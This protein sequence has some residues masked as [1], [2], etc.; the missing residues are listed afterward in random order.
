MA[1][2]YL[3][4]TFGSA[5]NQK[6]WT[7]SGWIKRGTITTTQV[8][9]TNYTSSSTRQ[10]FRFN[11][12]DQFETYGVVGGT[13]IIQANT[14][15]V[16]RDVSA[17]YHVVVVFNTTESTG[18]NRCKVYINGVQQSLT[19][20]TTPGLDADGAINDNGLHSIGNNGNGGNY[21][22]GSMAMVQFVDG[23]AYDATYFGST[24]STTGIWTSQASSTISS[25]G[26]NGFK[27]AMDT[28]TPGADTSG[29]TN[30][31]T[32]SGT[33]TLT[34]GSPDNNWCTLNPLARRFSSSPNTFSNGNTTS[35]FPAVNNSW[36]PVS[37][38]FG[39]TKGKW[40]WES[41]SI[42]GT[43]TYNGI[44]A[45][46]PTSNTGDVWLGGIA[47][48][49]GYSGGNGY[50]YVA[51]SN[52]ASLS[53]YT[54][55]DIVS[56]AYDAD[57]NLI[58]FYKNGAIQNSGTGLAVPTPESTPLGAWFPAWSTWDQTTTV[59]SFNF[60]EGFFGT[61]AAGTQADDNGQGLFAYDVPAGYYALNTKNLEAYG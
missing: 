57:N 50:V 32:A 38:T 13:D 20:T 41:K 26:T 61:T 36:N 45:Q 11:S 47:N 23:Q 59:K 24:D 44:M 9:F 30:N 5:G 55:G 49:F 6:T 22:D 56:V 35:T 33:P 4:K 8:F 42:S 40:Y 10:Y 28:T 7:W 46:E 31:F 51:N 27:L 39:M 17:W 48:Q 37:A 29:N 1:T 16:F 60:G 34:Q 25:Y 3:S 2:T 21:V 58:Y 52:Q 12:S 43:A 14:T 15:S 53:S 54:N 19:F 18:S